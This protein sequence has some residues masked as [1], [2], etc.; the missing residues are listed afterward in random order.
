MT[1]DIGRHQIN[2]LFTVLIENFFQEMRS[3]V[4][5]GEISFNTSLFTDHIAG[6]IDNLTS[7]LPRECWQITVT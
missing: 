5:V 7:D 2:V 3:C 6:I 4:S 1:H